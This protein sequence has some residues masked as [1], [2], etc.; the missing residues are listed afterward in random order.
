[1][2][3]IRLRSNDLQISPLFVV[4]EKVWHSKN[5][6]NITFSINIHNLYQSLWGLVH[7]CSNYESNEDWFINRFLRVSHFSVTF[8]L[9]VN[10]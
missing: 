8:K 6:I 2:N 1:M 4:A 9:T 7:A 10:L 5:V 3:T